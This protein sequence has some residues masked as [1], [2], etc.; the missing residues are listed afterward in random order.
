MTSALK[1]KKPL[2]VSSC[3]P[4]NVVSG[5]SACYFYGASL[6]MAA[7]SAAVLMSSCANAQSTN[8]PAPAVEGASGAASPT[9]ATPATPVL[10]RTELDHQ[11]APQD[12]AKPAPKYNSK[13][14]ERAFTFMD[15]DRD[16]KISRQEASGFRNVAKHFDAADT[17][18]DNYLSLEEFGNALNRP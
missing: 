8:S 18:K 9:P 4:E 17:N 2:L 14:I 3:F 5:F 12:A 7:V 6:T 16:G 11:P 10:P 15:T 13:D 1:H